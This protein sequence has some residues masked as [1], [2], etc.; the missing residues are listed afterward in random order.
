MT[1]TAEGFHLSCP[2]CDSWVKIRTSK[3]MTPTYRV[4][5]VYCTNKDGCG[6]RAT[7]DMTMGDV[8]AP[9]KMPDPEVAKTETLA[10][11]TIEQLR[12]MGYEVTETKPSTS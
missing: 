4:L 7:A 3:Q 6:W 5:Y 11:E 12:Q 8:I 9:S 2:H 10:P 1:N